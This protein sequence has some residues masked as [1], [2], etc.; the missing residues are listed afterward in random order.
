MKNLTRP[1]VLVILCAVIGGAW[2][3]ASGQA[4]L[5]RDRP[6]VVAVVS[7]EEVWNQVDERE[8]MNADLQTEKEELLAD[9]ERREQKIKN[10]QQDI[11][12][13]PE[14]SEERAKK[15]EELMQEAIKFK[16]WWEWQQQRLAREEKIRY[17]QLYR[18]SV[19][20]IEEVAEANG[21]DIVL[22]KERPPTFD[23][24]LNVAQTL[25]LIGNRKVLYV[26][27]ELNLTDQVITRMNNR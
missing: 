11:D 24:K 8:Q 4:E 12:W 22:F 14:D 25:A 6:A 3:V 13:S 9:K 16:A 26:R 21:V 20:A 1:L 15:E 27:D 2:V 18:N 10:M 5:L 7:L 23:P 19:S 17:E